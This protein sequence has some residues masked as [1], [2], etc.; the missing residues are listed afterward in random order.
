MFQLEIR[1]LCLS[2]RGL[3][4][5]SDVSFGLEKGLLYSIIGPNGAG[6]TSLLNCIN[7]FYHPE[8]GEI[9]YEGSTINGLKSHE[10]AKRGIARTFQNIELFG[11][12]PVIDNIKLGRHLLMKSGPFSS[13]L[14]LGRARREEVDHRKHIEE[15]I[16]DLLELEDIRHELVGMLPYGLQKRV[17]LG[18]AL[19]MEPKILLLDEPTGGMN[20]EETEDM[21]R[22]ILLIR[23]NWDL[24][25]VLIE[26]DMK[27]VMDIS[28]RVVVLNFGI[29]I[30][31]G[32]PEHVMK[33]PAVIDA[34]LGKKRRW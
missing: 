32:S 26:H 29:K 5:L 21:V 20:I 22:Y 24:T 4:A 19:A 10:I 15:K 33:D 12:M 13:C 7:S 1:K 14:Y 30:A 2:F 18:R 3:R 28:D 25:T 27:V 6:K 23:K 34:Y 16:I 9:L 31:E 17:E 8:S 11:G